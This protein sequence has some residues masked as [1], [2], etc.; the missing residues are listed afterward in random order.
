MLEF[1]G[2]KELGPLVRVVCTKDPKIS[3]DF[4]IGSFCLS[5]SLRMI[6][7]READIIFEDS[8][9]FPSKG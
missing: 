4:L 5:I 3:F 1:S 7:S 9:K 2:G 8:S 6:S